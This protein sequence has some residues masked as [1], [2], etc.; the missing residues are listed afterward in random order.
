MVWTIRESSHSWRIGNT[1]AGE[2]ADKLQPKIQV[3]QGLQPNPYS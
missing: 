3:A 2:I 1:N